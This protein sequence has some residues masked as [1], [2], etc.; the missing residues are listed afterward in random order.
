MSDLVNKLKA[1]GI[2]YAELPKPHNAELLYNKEFENLS[3]VE[4][5]QGFHIVMYGGHTP[6]MQCNHCGFNS[7][8]LPE[9]TGHLL[10]R[11]WLP[12]IDDIKSKRMKDQATAKLQSLDKQVEA[13]DMDRILEEAVS[14]LKSQGIPINEDR[15]DGN[16]NKTKN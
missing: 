9:V 6:L 16:S 7:A 1:K 8:R 5:T 12:A 10:Q 11:H 14:D 3:E 13:L 15:I 2:D 4:R